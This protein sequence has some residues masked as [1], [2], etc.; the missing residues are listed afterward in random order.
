MRPSLHL[1]HRIVFAFLLL[2]GGLLT[3]RAEEEQ[4]T[5]EGTSTNNTAGV[6]SHFQL[7]MKLNEGQIVAEMTTKVPMSGNGTLH[8]KL[9]NGLCQL[10][11]ELKEGYTLDLIGT[12][13]AQAFTGRFMMTLTNGIQ[14]GSFNLTRPS[15]SPAPSLAAPPV[16]SEPVSVLPKVVRVKGKLVTGLFDRPTGNGTQIGYVQPGTQLKLIESVLVNRVVWL[17][18][19]GQEGTVLTDQGITVKTGWLRGNMVEAVE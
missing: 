8:G 2:A 13:D 19:Q 14:H 7:A 11:G 12:L 6:I 9:T 4:R 5:Y 15:A 1:V 3:V 17:R 10:S 18:V 16:K